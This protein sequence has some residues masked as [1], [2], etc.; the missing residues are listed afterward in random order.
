MSKITVSDLA[1]DSK[2]FINEVA[3]TESS[4][5]NGGGDALTFAS[6]YG[7]FVIEISKI[8]QNSF[9]KGTAILAIAE[10]AK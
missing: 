8:L 6:S 10:L 1:F 5:V 7:G 9:L 2:S 3:E 4:S